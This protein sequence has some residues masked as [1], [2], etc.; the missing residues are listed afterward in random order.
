MRHRAKVGPICYTENMKV[1]IYTDGSSRGNPGPGGWASIVLT[2]NEV[3]EFGGGEK[4][5]T[6]NRMELMG[7][8]HGLMA[9][10]S[11]QSNIPQ[12]GEKE[13]KANSQKVTAVEICTDSEYVKK[14]MTEWIAGW[15]KKGWKTSTK[16]PVLNQ[17]L[18]EMLYREEKRLKDEGIHMSWTYVKAHVGIPLN[19]RAD[20]I[21]TGYADEMIEIGASNLQL[22]RGE[23]EAYPYF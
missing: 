9:V 7:A 17:D 15:I 18:W 23:K 4:N 8:I 22:Y 11:R 19:E 6:N 21:A 3:F 16:K 20:T 10:Y 13:L 12:T 1:I 14:G 2:E 5:T